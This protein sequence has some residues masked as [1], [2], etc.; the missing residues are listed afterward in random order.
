MI[1][2]T[3]TLRSYAVMMLAA[4]S[5]VTLVGCPASNSS[6][7]QSQS[8]P[9]STVHMGISPYPDTGLPILSEKLGYF[10]DAGVPVQL[11]A[12]QWSEVMPALA[13]GSLDVV[14]QNMNS[15]QETYG[16]LKVK[17]KELVFTRPLFVFRGGALMVRGGSGLK[18]LSELLKA[19]PDRKEALRRTILQL[20]GKTLITPQGTDH[21]QMVMAAL[22]FAGLSERDVR[23]RHAEGDN[24]VAAFVGGEDDA[25]TGGLVQRLAVEKRG[26]FMLFEM[27][28][29]MPPVINGLICTKDFAEKHKSELD[30]IADAWFKTIQY[31]DQDPKGRSQSF[32]DYLASQGSAKFTPDQYV[33]VF[34]QGDVFPKTREEAKKL[35]D[36]PN[37]KYYWKAS[38]DAIGQ[39]LLASNKIKAAA[40]PSAYEPH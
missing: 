14:V 39:F 21:E 33:N 11:K 5:L 10:K 4:A 19:F 2:H 24:G 28:D 12:L 9:V 37:S 34:R 16:N 38:W 22:K 20:R 27:D 18:P 26:G 29:V 8:E 40:P 15:F 1:K 17:G 13:A 3:K 23:I 25:V 36:D 7:K 31:V 35:F 32:L 30:K 6:P